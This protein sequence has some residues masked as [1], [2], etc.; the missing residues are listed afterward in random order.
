MPVMKVYHHGG[1]VGVPPRMNG[2]QRVKRGAVQGWSYQSIRNNTRFLY[3]IEEP[4]LTGHGL[5]LTLT[6]RDCPP[7][8]EDWQSLRD[9]FFYRLRKL[10][11]QGHTLLRLHWVTEWQRRGVPHLHMALWFDVPPHPFDLLRIWC[12]IASDCGAFPRGQHVVPITDALGWFQYLSKHASR[13]LGHYQRHPENVPAAWERTGR[14]WGYLGEWPRREAM[15]FDLEDAAF[16]ALRRMVRGYRRADARRA[17]R[18]LEGD[19]GRL[20]RSPGALGQLVTARRRIRQARRM[21]SCPDRALSSV[22]GVSEWI[23]DEDQVG[24]L[25]WLA[26]VG[27]EVEQREECP[28]DGTDDCPDE[29]EM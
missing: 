6:V 17:V 5:A 26:S 27:F 11:R 2:H 24:M 3:S 29:S 28:D 14:M 18:R 16:Y 22:R 7:T 1:T 9:R 13:G 23:S 20:V 15:V 25:V 8:H 19:L 10:R 12:D 21:L 4:G